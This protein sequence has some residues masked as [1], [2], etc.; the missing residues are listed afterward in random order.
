MGAA[1]DALNEAIA[2]HEAS[3]QE[4][5]RKKR[6]EIELEIEE[7]MLEELKDEGELKD[8]LLPYLLEEKGFRRTT[9]ESGA[10]SLERI[11][12]EERV[13][14]MSPVEQKQLALEESILN[15]ELVNR[16]INPDTMQTLTQEERLARMTPEERELEGLRSDILSR[17]RAAFAGELPVSPGLERDIERGR[18]AT[19]SD[20]RRRL[21]PLG[22]VASTVG[23]E[24]IGEFEERAFTVREE[25]RRRQLYELEGLRSSLAGGAGAASMGQFNI[26]SQ[27][28]QLLAG[29]RGTSANVYGGVP[30]SRIGQFQA[31]LQPF[32]YQRSLDLQQMQ[33]NQQNQRD[34]ESDRW[35]FAG[36]VIGGLI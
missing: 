10:V 31:A 25:D 3:P 26:A 20:I 8:I 13:A 24:A 23:R 18:E 2:E 14:G 5:T 34:R 35:G 30:G 22:D 6:E 36:S 19:T 4:Q 29:S 1:E 21:G 32:Q 7:L 33:F 11:P 27:L 9:D 17:E 12:W 28:Q 15:K 16:G